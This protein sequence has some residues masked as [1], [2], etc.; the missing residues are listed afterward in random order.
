[1][2]ITIVIVALIG[3]IS[4]AMDMTRE[5][6]NRPSDALLSSQFA[7]SAVAAVTLDAEEIKGRDKSPTHLTDVKWVSELGS[8]LLIG[9]A[10]A[11]FITAPQRKIRK[12]RN[13]RRIL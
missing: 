1:M 10:L 8:I 4:V 13:E 11:G 3:L 9:V 12:A 2:R 5:V 6:E 7:D